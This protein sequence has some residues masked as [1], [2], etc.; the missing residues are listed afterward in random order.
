MAKKS[1]FI[2]VCLIAFREFS[3]LFAMLTYSSTIFI[4]AGSS[5]SPNL[6]SIA[7]GFM[8]LVGSYVST[9]LVDRAGR[10]VSS[11]IVE[12]V[13]ALLLNRLIT[14]RFWLFFPPSDCVSH[15]A[16]WVSSS[17]WKIPVM[18]SLRWN[19][20]HWSASQRPSSSATLERLV[21]LMLW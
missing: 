16:R 9:L 7:I 12:M 6:S 11:H 2:G 20:Y 21:Y 15:W 19:G 18:M 10:K 13:N 1:I 14:S 3:G 5:L 4:E 17:I 8:Q